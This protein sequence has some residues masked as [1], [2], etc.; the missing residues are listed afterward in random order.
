MVNNDV[1]IEFSSV[2]IEVYMGPGINKE[3]TYTCTFGCINPKEIIL[4]IFFLTKKCVCL[5]SK[6]IITYQLLIIDWS[7]I[8]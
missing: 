5:G 7:E 3:D 8:Q 1:S 4:G 2:P 6:L